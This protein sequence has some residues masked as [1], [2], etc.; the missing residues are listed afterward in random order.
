MATQYRRRCQTKAYRVEED[1]DE[2]AKNDAVGKVTCERIHMHW[3]LV[4]VALHQRHPAPQIR[5]CQYT[6]TEA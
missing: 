3:V 2:F 1:G 6:L 4:H 5:H